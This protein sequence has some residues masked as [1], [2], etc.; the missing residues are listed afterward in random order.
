[1]ALV[2]FQR[3]SAGYKFKVDEL[4]AAGASRAVAYEGF[5]RGCRS[6]TSDG[7]ADRMNGSKSSSNTLKESEATWNN[8]QR[9]SAATWR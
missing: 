6:K 9:S 2:P 8:T 5:V 4:G 3:G 1:M 7:F